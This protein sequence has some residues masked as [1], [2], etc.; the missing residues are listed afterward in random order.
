MPNTFASNLILLGLNIGIL[1]GYP[2]MVVPCI[3][4]LNTLLFSFATSTKSTDTDAEYIPRDRYL[5]FSVALVLAISLVA[6][7]IPN[8]KMILS[9]LLAHKYCG[10]FQ[11]LI[12]QKVKEIKKSSFVCLIGDLIFIKLRK[13][14]IYEALLLILPIYFIL[15]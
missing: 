13:S 8:G 7:F 9:T 4:S 15:A 10:Q 11:S 3:H 1:T 14:L 5:F 12:F 6:F 2:Y